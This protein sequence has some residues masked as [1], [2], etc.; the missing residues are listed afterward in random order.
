MLDRL[1]LCTLLHMYT[2]KGPFSIKIPVQR[3]KVQGLGVVGKSRIS[4]RFLLRAHA[5]VFRVFNSDQRVCRMYYYRANNMIKFRNSNRLYIYI[6]QS[7]FL[8]KYLIHVG[9]RTPQFKHIFLVT[10][11]VFLSVFLKYI[12]TC[13]RRTKRS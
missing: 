4:P 13:V 5:H 3:Q 7:Q 9:T 12:H 6:Q 11:I 10:I 1:V 2:K 8:P